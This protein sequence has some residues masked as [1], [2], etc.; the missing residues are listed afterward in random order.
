MPVGSL[1]L[2]N[3]P[4][5]SAFFCM[6]WKVFSKLGARFRSAEGPTNND[7]IAVSSSLSKLII[8][9]E[10]RYDLLG[11]WKLVSLKARAP[12]TKQQGLLV[13]QVCLRAP[14]YS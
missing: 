8:V 3:S 9:E 1:N 2:Q 14:F 11:Q 10:D 5:K 4:E 13:F 12:S 7:Y 6:D